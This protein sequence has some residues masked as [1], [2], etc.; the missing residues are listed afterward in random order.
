MLAFLF[1]GSADADI[2]RWVD[3]EGRRHYSD[4]PP[5]DRAVDKL[6][7]LPPPPSADQINRARQRHQQLRDR[8]QQMEQRRKQWTERRADRRIEE[9]TD[10][11]TGAAP[12]DNLVPGS[13]RA[14]PGLQRDTLDQLLS[15]EQEYRPEC[16]TPTAADTAVVRPLSGARFQSGV[17]MEGQW[18]E[19]W[20]LDSC[21]TAVSYLIEY[22]ADGSGG[23]FLGIRV[24]PDLK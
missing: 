19:R 15:Y 16:E 2:Y 17:L 11:R 6:D 4:R 21:G 23:V 12:P 8:A 20:T 24:P 18:A 13:T 1:A 9:D 10:P 22:S 7:P 5:D 3:E 14:V